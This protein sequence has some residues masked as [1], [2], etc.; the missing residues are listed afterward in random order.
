MQEFK[1]APSCVLY[2]AKWPEILVRM[3][4]FPYLKEV[5]SSIAAIKGTLII[6]FFRLYVPSVEIG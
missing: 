1:N 3:F 2:Y 5:A 6:I 4:I